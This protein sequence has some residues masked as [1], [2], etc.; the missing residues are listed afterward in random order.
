MFHRQGLGCP[1]QEK[2]LTNKHS[3]LRCHA[4][5]C[6]YRKWCDLNHFDSMLP[7][8]SK[9]RKRVEKDRQ[10]LVINHF[11][12]EDLTMRPISFSD[13]ALQT[14][15]LEWM[16]ATNQPIQAFKNATFK[17]MLDIASRANWNI[18]LPSPK[19]SRA[20]I[21]KMFKQQL[22]S[23]QDRLNVTFF[24]FFFSFHVH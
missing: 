3:T 6:H 16:V 15:A 2:F 20:Q 13:K 10:S 18:R 8:D 23:L 5:A 17:K 14:A 24:F 11:G 22:H 9:K 12:P 4:A 21:I 19:Q 7:Q 1:K